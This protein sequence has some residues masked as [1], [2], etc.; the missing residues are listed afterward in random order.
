VLG[1]KGLQREANTIPTTTDQLAQI[2]CRDLRVE[3]D[4]GRLGVSDFSTEFPAGEITAIVGPSGC[5][6]ST[7]LRTVA[8]L[9]SASSGEVEFSPPQSSAWQGN[10]SFVFQDSA[11]V[12]WRTAR[13]NVQLPLELTG[14][15]P[16]TEWETLVSQHLRSVELGA[17]DDAKRSS[18]LSGGMRMRVSIARALVTDP[19]IL[20]LDEPFAALDEMLRTRLGELLVALWRQRRRTILFVTHNIA[21]AILLS[22]RVV[23]M[24]QG[25]LRAELAN[26]LP[27]PRDTAVRTTT[28]FSKFYADVATELAE[29]S[30]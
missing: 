4:D 15:Q 7:L 20:L 28:Q 14:S 8:G 10:L 11:L 24:S 2:L 26:P 13:E 19:A 5:G 23:I 16:T 17:E 22:H 30:T 6:K 21:E 3:F 1:I 27:F 25:K 9:I 18:Q 12:P 29:V